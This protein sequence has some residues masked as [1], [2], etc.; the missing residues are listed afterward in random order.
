VFAFSHRCL[1][2]RSRQ[3][4]RDGNDLVELARLGRKNGAGQA[5]VSDYLTR[6]VDSARGA[7]RALERMVPLL[8]PG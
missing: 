3:Y 8:P 2:S 7:A 4:A 6:A 1:R 5:A